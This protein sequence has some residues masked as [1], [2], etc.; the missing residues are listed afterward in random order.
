L[1]FDA[2]AARYARVTERALHNAAP[3]MHFIAT[4]FTLTATPVLQGFLIKDR[5]RSLST[6]AQ[7][8]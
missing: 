8:P 1:T 2:D 3:L 5:N 6:A 4:A 7:P